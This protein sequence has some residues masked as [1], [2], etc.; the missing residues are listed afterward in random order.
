MADAFY[1]TEVTGTPTVKVNGKVI[2][3]LGAD[4]KP[5]SVQRFTQAAQA[6]LAAS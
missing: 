1:T 3:V 4:G 2:T 6:A 5:V